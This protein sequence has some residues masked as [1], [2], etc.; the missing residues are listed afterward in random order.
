M[1]YSNYPLGY[2]IWSPDNKRIAFPFD[3]YNFFSD[4]LEVNSSKIDSLLGF[5]F[6][7]F[8]FSNF[9]NLLTFTPSP[10]LKIASINP[11]DL[12]LTKIKSFPY[13]IRD[14]LIFSNDEKYYA[15]IPFNKTYP[16]GLIV[17][18]LKNSDTMAIF[19]S[20]DPLVT[21]TGFTSNYFY[22]QGN[23]TIFK[24]DLNDYHLLST[25]YL[26]NLNSTI[27]NDGNLA[28]TIDVLN[29]LTLWNLNDYKQVYTINILKPQ[30]S[31][32]RLVI[33]PDK[34]Y[35]AVS[36]TIDGAIDIN[37]NSYFECYDLKSGIK[38]W[39]SNYDINA[40]QCVT[41]SPDNK[42]VL[43]SNDDGGLTLLKREN[44]ELIRTLS[45]RKYYADKSL[46]SDFSDDSIHFAFAYYSNG[47]KS[48]ENIMI[49][50]INELD[51]IDTLFV[52]NDG[53]SCLKYSP[54]GKYLAVGLKK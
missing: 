40:S 29:N 42:Y 22:L 2:I 49:Y 30:S 18:T 10:L 26:P 13:A 32:I 5:K 47:N 17:Y 37:I 27:S 6:Q 3:I 45:P 35:F 38:L 21:K 43:A 31:N 41:I 8:I 53:S 25:H 33:S 24:Y 54:D 11:N 14:F 19:P 51:K 48:E 39:N 34:K 52:G 23:D 9:S 20:F 16:L 1:W 36:G 15:C 44:G 12:K 7:N 50:N 4:S 28:F 46:N